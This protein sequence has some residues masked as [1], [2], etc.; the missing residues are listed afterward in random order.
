MTHLGPLSGIRVVEL[1]VVI[2]G[3]SAAA[4]LG[5]WGADVVKVEPAGGDPQRGNTQRAYFELDNRGKRSLTIDLK[6]DRGRELLTELIERADVFVTNIR[7]GALGRLGLDPARLMARNRR[8]VYASIGGYSASGPAADKPGYD[9]GAF[10][11]RAGV[12][13]ALVGPGNEPDVPRPGLGDHTTALSLVAGIGAALVERART[14]QGRLVT[15][16][17]L[18]TGAFVISSD[19]CAQLAGP[20]PETGLRRAMYNPLLACYRAADG[21]WFWLLG[22]QVERHWPRILR[23]VAREDLLSDERFS[24]FARILRNGRE[25]IAILDEEFA[26]HTLD[27]WAPIFAREDVWWD[28]V[29]DLAEVLDDPVVHASGALVATGAGGRTIAAP[30]DFAG[31]DPGPAQRAPE[32]G[33]HTEEILLELG[34]DWPDIAALQSDGVIP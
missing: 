11:S 4:I 13:S 28:P 32:A 30:V 14:G 12:A 34:L 15:T 33:E 16:S 21:R 31:F 19:L 20:P 1:G 27:E 29:Q 9:V 7:P 23:A 22:L 24:S 6:T 5:D 26:R 18:R 8:L 25:L 2:A 17:L 10:W 3:P